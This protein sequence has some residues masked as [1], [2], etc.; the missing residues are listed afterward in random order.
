MAMAS[1]QAGEQGVQ[2]QTQQVLGQSAQGQENVAQEAL[3]QGDHAHEALSQDAVGHGDLG[4][5][6]VAHL[7]LVDGHPVQGGPAE[8]QELQQL[9]AAVVEDPVPPAVQG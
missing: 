5:E 3:G 8:I 6:A 4:Q 7:G 9:D 2:D 1:I